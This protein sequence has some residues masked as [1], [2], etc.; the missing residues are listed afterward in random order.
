VVVGPYAVLSKLYSAARNAR[1][2]KLAGMNVG[3]WMSPRACAWKIEQM[4]QSGE[5]QRFQQAFAKLCAEKIAEYRSSR[6]G[7]RNRRKIR[8]GR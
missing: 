6:K 7:K 2:E 1:E 5:L 3:Y 8:G 4:R